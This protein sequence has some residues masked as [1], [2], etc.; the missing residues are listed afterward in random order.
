MS[1]LNTPIKRLVE[2]VKDRTQLYASARN[3]LKQNKVGESKVK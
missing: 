2:W 3:S 1:G